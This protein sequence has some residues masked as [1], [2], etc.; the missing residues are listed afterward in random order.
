M[1][2]RVAG[3]MPVVRLNPLEIEFTISD[4]DMK[5]LL[6]KPIIATFSASCT[7]RAARLLKI[8]G[9]VTPETITSRVIIS[10]HEKIPLQGDG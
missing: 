3:I 1:I 7:Y 10:F 6:Q 5:L 9:R 2:S 8:K 4:N